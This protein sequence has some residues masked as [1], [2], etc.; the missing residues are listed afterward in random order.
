MQQVIARVMNESNSYQPSCE[1]KRSVE[2]GLEPRTKRVKLETA[3]DEVPS[4]EASS[5]S[6]DSDEGIEKERTMIVQ[7]SN[8]PPQ[9]I[10]PQDANALQGPTSTNEPQG[11]KTVETSIPPNDASTIASTAQQRLKQEP[12]MVH[13][14]N[15]QASKQPESTA[16]P[17]TQVAQSSNITTQAQAPI[18]KIP[19]PPPPLK[20][21]TMVHLKTKY[22][23]QL[24]YMHR[25]FKKLEEQ[26][27]GA[28]ANSKSGFEAEGSMERRKKLNSFILHLQSTMKKI[29]LGCALELK[30]ESML[31]AAA[32]SVGSVGMQGPTDSQVGSLDSNATVES[33]EEEEAK[34]EFARTSALT[35]LTKEKEEEE[36]VQK[37]EEHILADLLPVKVRLSKQ[38]AAQ[39]GAARNPAGMPISRANLQPST[40][41][42]G[43][44]TF[45]M[46]AEQRQA[47]LQNQ[48]ELGS[49][50]AALNPACTGPIAAPVAASQFGKPLHGGGSS[51]TQ[52][53]HGRTLG[54]SKRAGGYGVGYQQV[55]QP[56]LPASNP[57]NTPIIDKKT[58]HSSV[59]AGSNIQT[60]S[61]R[62]IL[63]AG[64]T[65]GSSQIRS[66][67]SAAAGAHDMVIHS[68]RLQS[69]SGGKS[70]ASSSQPPPSPMLKSA[71]I[72]PHSLSQSKSTSTS[73]SPSTG[74]SP[75]SPLPVKSNVGGTLDQKQPTSFIPNSHTF[76]EPIPKAVS[77]QAGN[78]GT[79]IAM[80]MPPPPGSFPIPTQP[81][82]S[83]TVIPRPIKKSLKD[84]N[85]TDEERQEIREKRKRKKVEKR[86]AR[87]QEEQRQQQMQLIIQ[88][89]QR[90]RQ[91]AA[92][93]AGM[94]NIRKAG[95]N[96]RNIVSLKKGPRNVE[97]ICSLCNETYNSTCEHNPWWALTSHDCLKCGKTQ[98]PRLDISSPSNII[99]YHPA[100]LAHVANDDKG[101][102]KDAVQ[103]RLPS[104]NLKAHYS[105]GIQSN[106]NSILLKGGI[107]GN[108]MNISDDDDDLSSDSDSEYGENMSPSAKAEN[109]DFGKDYSGPKMTDYDASRLLILMSHAST[110]PGRYVYLFSM[111]NIRPNFD[112]PP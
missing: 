83:M 34:K 11:G 97:Y 68:K 37:L 104:I 26:L 91:Q 64:M 86:V 5:V 44:G 93:A 36:H 111:H 95:S 101:G 107:Q 1:H 94:K 78:A 80:T 90:Q 88:Q 112:S 52:K 65:P 21:T 32:A 56:I 53:L 30:G 81:K 105:L 51:L 3:E 70:T 84:P 82:L 74:V 75:M 20:S 15:T 38:L 18:Q 62:Q 22:I 35:K 55:N 39:K 10:M 50:H 89:Q 12:G 31:G 4:A 85:L 2:S 77:I 63:Y 17:A 99:E 66:G 43:K 58:D 41:E 24:E 47:Q 7:C 6:G 29:E 69:V 54:S 71:T 25:E 28:K 106:Q 61:T 8:I 87:I 48:Q 60:G 27:L 9:R 19:T 102:N 96:G 92:A 40:C 110:C 79:S 49:S 13:V 16:V 14:N 46:A 59:E 103:S 45:A 108:D 98:V 76:S 100:L 72:D 67:V 42:K 73:R 23:P 33:Q 109:E 57:G